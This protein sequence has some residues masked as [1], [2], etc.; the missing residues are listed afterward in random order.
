[1]SQL[2]SGDTERALAA[3]REKLR[4]F[5]ADRAPIEMA[6]DIHDIVRRMSG[7]ADPY[8]A[9]KEASNEV[10][11]SYVSLIDIWMSDTRDPL[12]TAV[13]LSIAGNLID[14]G[15]FSTE[16]FDREQLT[17]TLHAVVSESLTGDTPDDM[18]RAV[19][20]ARR[21][22]FI[23]D[24]AG[25]CFFDRALLMCLPRDRLT[26][27]VRGRPVLNDATRADAETAGIH[28]LCPV[29]DTGDATPGILLER[30][31][32]EF[33]DAFESSDLVIAKGQG[34]YESL[35]G[36]DDRAYIFLARVKCDAI[37]ADI[38]YPVGSNILRLVTPAAIEMHE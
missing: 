13:K 17:K 34:N 5:T 27:A 22:L 30:S 25:E 23:G 11:A 16:T 24:N 6:A 18:M 10:C 26:Y 28:R 4:E 35:S 36:R 8:A 9:I 14:F 19:D 3:V 15:A 29:I 1:M 12:T 37:A 31:S 21:I 20:A 2:N 7:Q 33:V 32:A 38:G